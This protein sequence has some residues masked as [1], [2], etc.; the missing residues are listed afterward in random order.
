MHWS[1]DQVS[2]W[3][4][5]AVEEFGFNPVNKYNWQMSGLQLCALSK[6]EFLKR[7][8][9]CTGDVLHSHL[10][11]LKAK[12]ILESNSLSQKFVIALCM[13]SH[14]LTTISITEDDTYK[15][16]NYHVLSVDIHA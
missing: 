10:N 13:N 8:Q 1:E 5:W 3:L 6:E 4:D 15:P 14:F 16:A 12:G 11:L 2:Q 7:A 9:P